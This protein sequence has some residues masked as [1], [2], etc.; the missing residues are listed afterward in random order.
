MMNQ[1]GDLGFHL[2]LGRYIL[3]Q[4]KIPL[5]DLFS[6]TMPGKPVIQH[7]WL[8]GV[9]F[10]IIERIFGFEGLILLCA[11]LIATTFWLVLKLVKAKTE[12]LI[13][14]VIVILLTIMTS[15]VHWLARPHLFSFL[16]L[17]LWMMV[18]KQMIEGKLKRWWMLPA[19]MLIWTN[20]HGG[21]IIGFLT[22]FIYGLG[23]GWDA[24]QKDITI[25]K[26]LPLKFWYYFI[27]GGISSF[28]VS[29]INP[30]GFGLWEKVVTHIG[31]K[32]LN[33]HTLEFQSPNFHWPSFWPF[34]IFIG[35][36]I[37]VLGLS[38]KKVSF[39]DLLTTT[40]WLLL[41]LYSSRNVPL[42]AIVAAPLLAQGLDNLFNDA[43]SQFR[44][45][46]YLR[47]LVARLH[48]VD[49][50]LK[51]CFWPIISIIVVIV[52]LVLGFHFDKE[53]KGYTFDP[54]VFP[55][56]A[57]NWLEENPQEGEMFNYYTWGGYLLLMEK[58]TSMVRTLHVNMHKS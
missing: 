17:A 22:W 42:F 32:Y 35:L 1:D 21:F 25:K 9:I 33:D 18:M 7:E 37:I 19:L 46:K 13:I 44:L 6:H 36:L 8:S 45:M 15:M 27:L 58:L 2:T 41:G 49:S 11:L 43:A 29:L 14:S 40:A 48:N 52:S 53:G 50:Q 23:L 4:G 57:V 54:E 55:V 12:N 39:E 31:N 24:L 47:N 5:N 16:L 38:K 10:A 34:V 26:R 3:D 56:H 28:I 20:L 51:G 30:S